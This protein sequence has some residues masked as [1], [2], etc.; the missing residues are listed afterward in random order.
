MFSRLAKTANELSPALM[1]R[2]AA[3]AL[4]VFASSVSAL[5]ATAQ[6]LFVSGPPTEL[7]IAPP[8]FAGLDPLPDEDSA[9][10]IVWLFSPRRP[11]KIV[12]NT[13]APGQSFR[14]FTEARNVFRATGMPEVQLFD[15][16]PGLDFIRDIPRRSFIGAASIYFRAEA[17]AQLGNS[18]LYGDDNHTVYFTWT[19]Q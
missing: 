16:G 7:T 13:V 12:V 11:S 15:G 5:E 10:R 9:T 17:P 4:F 6:L 2:L 3:F 19:A 14:L 18:Q 8:S 1:C